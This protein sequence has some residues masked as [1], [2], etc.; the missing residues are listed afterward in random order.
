M[1]LSPS[2]KFGQ[3]IGDLLEEILHRPLSQVAKKH[4]LY[5]DVKHPRPARNNRKLVKWK[6]HK[7]NDH[8]LDFVFEQGGS[9]DEIGVPKAFIESAWRRYTK[10]SRNKAQEIQGAITVLAETYSQHKPFLGAVL[11]GVYTKGSRRQ[12]ESHGFS[13]LYC[14]YEVV[15]KAFA[16]VGIDAAFDEDTPTKV[17]QDK[18]NAYDALTKSQRSV[19]RRRFHQLTRDQITLFISELESSLTRGIDRIRV[20]TLHGSVCQ[21]QSVDEAVQFIT[22]YDEEQDI[23]GFVRYEVDIRYTNGDHVN[24]EFELK[25]TAIRFLKDLAEG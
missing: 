17:L 2:H 8:D 13:L 18:V 25:A 16:S 24:G 11:A 10:H 15:L 1:A 9:E 20:G 12:L 23:N 3:I 5:L 22:A 6:D 21:L 4:G 14:P 7:G 19:L